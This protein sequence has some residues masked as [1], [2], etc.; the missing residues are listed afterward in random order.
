MLFKIRNS[1]D[2]H[3]YI[4]LIDTKYRQISLLNAHADEIDDLSL[5]TF[6]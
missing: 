6:T 3:I 2:N 1:L 4:S 5:E